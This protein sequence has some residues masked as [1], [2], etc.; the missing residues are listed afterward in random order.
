M[1]LRQ[2]TVLQH[3]VPLVQLNLRRRGAGTT[4][5]ASSAGG[6]F[7]VLVVFAARFPPRR[8]RMTD[9]DAL[10][11]RAV[12]GEGV[13]TVHQRRPGTSAVS[14]LVTT[15]L[16]LRSR[17]R[18][19]ALLAG[20]LNATRTAT[21]SSRTRRPHGRVLRCN[22]NAGQTRCARKCSRS[23]ATT[24]AKVGLRG[25]GAARV[26]HAHG[27]HAQRS[28]PTTRKPLDRVRGA[29]AEP[30]MGRTRG[31]RRTAAPLAHPP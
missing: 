29:G 15:G 11:P 25:R 7:E 12:P 23:C 28:R 5:P 31:A 14:T 19:E 16:R 13:A 2:R 24:S 10:H 4:G 22:T 9:R 17:W 30:G 21:A 3:V 8:P 6:A 27:A 20:W 1:A 18:E 26:Q